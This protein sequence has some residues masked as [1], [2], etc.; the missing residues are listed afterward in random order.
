MYLRVFADSLAQ[1]PGR[2][3]VP[4]ERGEVK[5]ELSISILTSEVIRKI[6]CEIPLA[7]FLLPEDPGQQ[8]KKKLKIGKKKQLHEYIDPI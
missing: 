6:Q 5:G 7:C 1:P 8:S 3:R 2:R 4:G